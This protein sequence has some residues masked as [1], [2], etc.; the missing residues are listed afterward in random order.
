[1]EKN[2]KLI[3][4]INLGDYGST[5]NIMLNCLEYANKNGNF[6]VVALIPYETKQT[7]AVKTISFHTDISPIRNIK[8]RVLNKLRNPI[9]NDGNYYKEQTKTLIQLIKKISN[10]YDKTIIHLH[11][12]HHCNIDVT[13]FYKFLANN[14]FVC[15]YTLHDSWT[16]TGGCYFYSHIQCN[17]WMYGCK[18]CPLKIKQSEKQLKK[19]TK[20]LCKIQ[21]LTLLPCSA[22]L[23]NE[24]SRSALKT[25]PFIVNNGET[26]LKPFSGK[27]QLREK[28]NIKDKIV[29]IS[30]AAYWSDWK[31][32]NYLYEL[33][34]ILPENYVLL[35]IGENIEIKRSNIINP[36]LITDS[37]LL[38]EHYSIS[39]VFVSVTQSDNLPLVLM[40]AQICG[41]PIVG[42]GHG[43][44]PELITNKS[45]IMA[46]TDNNVNIL[47]ETIKFVVEKKPFSKEDITA[48]GNRFKKY[49]CAKRQLDIYNK[50]INKN[51]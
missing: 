15:L 36:G 3:I 49:E 42:F 4:G 44:T 18:K 9:F 30:V 34:N 37:N 14:N 22:W 28:Y 13:Y 8:Y 50:A 40:E 6:D 33:S 35:L 1:M 24:L 19:R 25:I 5:G 20:Q 12:L 21:K 31:G 45:G 2:N 39:D 17:L 10:N 38:A 47:L 51:D 11:N 32:I 43:G 23:K 46:G 29:L 26:S 7:N 48:S 27:S 16:Y 41:L